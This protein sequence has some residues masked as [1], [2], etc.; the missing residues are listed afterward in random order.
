M[1]EYQAKDMEVAPGLQEIQI[2]LQNMDGERR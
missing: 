2:K 1:V